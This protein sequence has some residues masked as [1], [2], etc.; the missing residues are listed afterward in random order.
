MKMP[1]VVTRK[2]YLVTVNSKLVI[3]AAGTHQEKERHSSLIQWNVATFKLM[4]SN[5][6]QCSSHCKLVIVSRPADILTYI[7][8]KFSEFKKKQ[9]MF[10][11]VAVI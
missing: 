10:L 5:I 6:T 7:T 11:E 1:N 4:T 9:N 3:A 8:W 2:D